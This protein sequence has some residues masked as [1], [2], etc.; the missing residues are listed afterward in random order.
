MTT[1]ESMIKGTRG[2]VDEDDA[3]LIIDRNK[4]S[5]RKRSR[6]CTVTNA[7]QV[8]DAHALRQERATSSSSSDD[9]NSEASFWQHKYESLVA[10]RIDAENDFDKQ[11][12]VV[13]EIAQRKDAYIKLLERKIEKMSSSGGA[14]SNSNSHDD[15]EVKVKNRVISFYEQMT[16]MS[17]KVDDNDRGDQSNYICTIKNKQRRVA[18]RFIISIDDKTKRAATNVKYIP[19]AN[20]HVLPDYLHNTIEFEPGMSPVLLGDVLNSMFEDV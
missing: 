20:I 13:D 12:S 8:I 1:L 3:S 4:Y 9:V 17:V 16:C 2:I 18:S 5:S 15:D 19:C 10:E 11:L 14:S 7:D 6:L